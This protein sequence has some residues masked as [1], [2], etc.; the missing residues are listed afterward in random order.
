MGLEQHDVDLWRKQTDQGDSSTDVDGHTQGGE[1]DLWRKK[2]INYVIDLF[3]AVK[4][5]RPIGF[6]NRSYILI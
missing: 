1:L 2:S 5:E 4:I 3:L 6:L